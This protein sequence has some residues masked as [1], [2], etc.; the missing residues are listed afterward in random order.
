MIDASLFLMRVAY[1]LLLLSFHGAARFIRAF[2]Y[3]VHGEP[4]PFVDVVSQLG[5]PFA[6]A[7]AVASVLSESLGA[8]LIAA[9]LSTRAAA[10]CIAINM[11]VAVYNEAQKGDSIELAA[12]YLL[13]AAALLI[14]GSGAWSVDGL[15]RRRPRAGAGR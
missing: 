15:R 2:D 4:W 14:A 13:G 10:A 12:L 8:V 9:G 7:F 6:P 11:A 5:F 1:A 3:I